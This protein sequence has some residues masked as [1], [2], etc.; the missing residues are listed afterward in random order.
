MAAGIEPDLDFLATIKRHLPAIQGGEKLCEYFTKGHTAIDVGACGG[1]YSCVMATMFSKVLT[2]EPTADMAAL[3]RRSLPANCELLECALGSEIETVSIRVPKINGLRMN[4]LSTITDHNFEF[5]DIGVVDVDVVRQTTMDQLVSE[6]RLKPSFIKIDVEGY[7]GNVLM[8]A[9]QTVQVHK[10]VLMIEIEKRHNRNYLD[11]FTLL[12][13]YGYVPFHFRHGKLLPSG[14]AVVEE[15]FQVLQGMGVSG[16][17][18]MIAVKV[19]E[20]YLNNFI[21]LPL[22]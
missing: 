16:M 6:W 11:I 15:S 12:D 1:E 4:A 3:L 18:E 22:T 5:S 8:G 20:K 13:S 19:N 7:E 9:R 2:I 17:K 21:F 14:A 10:P